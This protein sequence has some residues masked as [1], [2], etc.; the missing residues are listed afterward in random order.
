MRL[1][2]ARA[3][4]Q[5]RLLLGVD[6]QSVQTLPQRGEELTAVV[7]ELSCTHDSTAARK[8]RGRGFWASKFRDL[9]SVIRGGGMR[10]NHLME[11][12]HFG[13]L[14]P[15]IV[16]WRRSDVFSPWRR[17]K[18]KG[19]LPLCQWRRPVCSPW[20][21]L[22]NQSFFGTWMAGQLCL[23]GLE[24]LSRQRR[25]ER[26]LVTQYYFLEYTWTR[27]QPSSLAANSMRDWDFLFHSLSSVA[28]KI[29]SSPTK[30]VDVEQHLV[31]CDVKIFPAVFP[32]C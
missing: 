10:K 1:L 2:A 18:P 30:S 21:H 20:C 5:R 8:R 17:D 31:R 15:E 24:F 12:G 25:K 16:V 3:F 4:C 28:N 29:C 22:N 23:T 19:T 32:Y 7:V 26:H 11:N 14:L 13:I 6:L 9:S 27:T